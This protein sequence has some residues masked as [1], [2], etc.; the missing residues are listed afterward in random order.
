MGAVGSLLDVLGL[1][2]PEAAAVRSALELGFAEAHEAEC[3]GTKATGG[4]GGGCLLFISPQLA[5]EDNGSPSSGGLAATLVTAITEARNRGAPSASLLWCASRD[6]LGGEG[7]Q[8]EKRHD[9]DAEDLAN[10]IETISVAR[11]TVLPGY[12]RSEERARTT[13]HGWARTMSRCLRG[14]SPV[15]ENFLIFGESGTGKTEFVKA[16]A[17]DC[18]ANVV[19]INLLE[20]NLAK[21]GA[22]LEEINRGPF[23]V[24]CIVDEV[25][26][27]L[28]GASYGLIFPRMSSRY[29][30]GVLFVFIGSTGGSLAGMIE[31]IEKK[32]PGDGPD[33]LTRIPVGHRVVMPEVSLLDRAYVFASQVIDQATHNG[34]SISHVNGAALYF[35]LAEETVSAPRALAQLAKTAVEKCQMTESDTVYF[36]D[37]FDVPGHSLKKTFEAR[38]SRQMRQLSERMIRLG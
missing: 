1:N 18:G 2:W 5:W 29:S 9:A 15:A 10:S 7:F 35:V 6:G 38:H 25:D 16:V 26:K 13:L 11:A 23:P 17:R 37:L 32:P 3:L 22:K 14:T 34:V 27:A 20:D 33:M 30:G 28:D 36:E 12:V 8:V 4:G 21:V 19:H 31:R 24:T